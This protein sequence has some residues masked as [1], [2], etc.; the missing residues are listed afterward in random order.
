VPPDLDA[1]AMRCLAQDPADRFQSADELRAALLRCE[2]APRDG[3]ADL[4]NVLAERFPAPEARKRTTGPDQSTPRGLVAQ[5]IAIPTPLVAAPSTLGS[6]ASQSLPRSQSKTR[7]PAFIAI[8]IAMVAIAAGAFLI[9][10]KLPELRA[11]H[12][13]DAG[14]IAI[15][16]EDARGIVRDAAVIAQPIDATVTATIPI[17]GPRAASSSAPVDAAPAVVT[18]AAH[19]PP[20]VPRAPSNHEHAAAIPAGFGELEIYV[21]PYAKFTINGGPETQTPL[22]DKHFP[23]GRYFLRYWDDDHKPETIPFTVSPGET[24]KIEKTWIPGGSE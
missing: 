16:H 7:S 24:T 17:D 21:H 10:Q 15:V 6:T 1:V 12:V 13:G 23:S 9:V 18:T 11:R 8:A 14:L 2:D 22:H 4:A 5:Q 20:K 3:R 19:E